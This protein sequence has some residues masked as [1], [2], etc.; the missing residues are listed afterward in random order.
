MADNEQGEERIASLE[1]ELEGAQRRVQAVRDE[2]GVEVAAAA[3]EVEAL[4]GRVV[5]ECKLVYLCGFLCVCV[6]VCA[7]ARACV[8]RWSGER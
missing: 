6:C 3:G 8:C 2:M 5:V 4:E 1:A 7:R